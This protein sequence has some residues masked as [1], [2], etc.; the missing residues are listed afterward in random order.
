MGISQNQV[1]Y[2][3]GLARNMCLYVGYEFM[4]GMKLLESI[5]LATLDHMSV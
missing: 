5:S 4:K 3:S 2:L 1:G